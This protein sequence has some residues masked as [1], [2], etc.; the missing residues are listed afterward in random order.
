MAGGTTDCQAAHLSPGPRPE[1][2]R[3]G[4][5]EGPASGILL[6]QGE[7]PAETEKVRQLTPE[8]PL[9]C[10]GPDRYTV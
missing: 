3:G 2:G 7:G 8:E 10:P 6:T 1:G 4:A 9:F 5:G